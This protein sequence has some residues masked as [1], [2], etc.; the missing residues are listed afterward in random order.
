[1][2]QE[3][4][5][6][7]VESSGSGFLTKLQSSFWP[8]LGSHLKLGRSHFQE[9]LL[10]GFNSLQTVGLKQPS[11]PHRVSL[12]SRTTCFCASQEGNG[13]SAGKKEVMILRKISKDMPSH[14]LCCI[15][16]VRS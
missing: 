9:R 10:A 3:F 2:G 13:E 6:S 11:V 5:H 16:F 7:L 1:M 4:R 8:G 12:P 14:H 15:L